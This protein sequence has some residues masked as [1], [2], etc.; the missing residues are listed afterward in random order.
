MQSTYIK[1]LGIKMKVLTTMNG[2]TI[3]GKLDDK[4][5]LFSPLFY[6]QRIFLVNKNAFFK[7]PDS[8]MS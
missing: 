4:F 6:I 5:A 8:F 2:G 1:L 7:S 3:M